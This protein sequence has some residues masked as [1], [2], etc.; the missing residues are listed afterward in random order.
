MNGF[1]TGQG[2]CA[3]NHHTW[4]LTDNNPLCSCRE[5]QTM[6]HTVDVCPSTKFPGGLRALLRALHCVD[7]AAAEWLDCH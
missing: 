7:D 2:H 3:A 5:L 1:R 4:G 6:S